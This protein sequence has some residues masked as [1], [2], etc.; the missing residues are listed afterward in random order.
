ME[1]KE[2]KAILSDALAYLGPNGE[3]WHKGSFF[4]DHYGLVFITDPEFDPKRSKVC[5][6]PL[7]AVCYAAASRLDDARLTELA[8]DPYGVLRDAVPESVKSALRT[9]AESLFPDRAITGAMGVIPNFNDHEDTTFWDVKLVFER[10]IE[11]L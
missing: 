9:S 3:R 1:N 10:A 11:S 7:G 5:A 8:Y 2:G 4:R 6:C